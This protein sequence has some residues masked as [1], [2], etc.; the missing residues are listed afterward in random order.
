V[1]SERAVLAGASAVEV[2]ASACSDVAASELRALVALELA[3][4]TV[5]APGTDATF[6]EVTRARVRCSSGRAHLLVEEAESGRKQELELDLRETLEAARTRLVALT[7]AELVA[8]LTIE[9][10]HMAE[11]AQPSAAHA[12]R[13][14]PP[15]WRKRVWLGAGLAREGRPHILAPTLQTGLLYPVARLPIALQTELLASRGRH[16]VTAGSITTWSLAG[17]AAAATRFRVGWA[18]LVLGVGARLGYARLEGIAGKDNTLSG[19]SL[20]GAFW[21]PLL[22]G[23][24]FAPLATRWGLRAG[25]DVVYIVMPVRGLD[26]SGK[27]VYALGGL[28]LQANM[29]ITLQL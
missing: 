20:S 5:A 1:A 13:A 15:P 8:T 18:E 29:S 7:L 10:T 3:P 21:G 14:Q 26:A 24:A 6:P 11:V 23:C 12:E 2:D 9:P 22:S 27:V 28:Q 16:D 17:S 25:L 4:R 19:R